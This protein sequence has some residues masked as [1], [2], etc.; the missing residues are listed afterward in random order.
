MDP[1]A[2]G[3]SD[4]CLADHSDESG[5]RDCIHGEQRE[6]QTIKCVALWLFAAAAAA[7][8]IVFRPPYGPLLLLLLLRA[9]TNF[10]PNKL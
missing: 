8:V 9:F 5:R 7:A 10:I 3:K 4:T 6:R 2:K 1:M